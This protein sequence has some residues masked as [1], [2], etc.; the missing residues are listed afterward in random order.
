MASILNINLGKKDGYT[1]VCNKDIHLDY[2][3]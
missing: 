3:T 2:S 1:V